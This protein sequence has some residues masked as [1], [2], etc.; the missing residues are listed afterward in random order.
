VCES[1]SSDKEQREL[2]EVDDDDSEDGVLVDDP[3]G[4]GGVE[5]ECLADF[6]VVWEWKV[7]RCKGGSFSEGFEFGGGLLDLGS[8]E[9]PWAERGR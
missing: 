5:S 1:V 9:L 3:A 8:G 7:G 6:G 4:L 2:P